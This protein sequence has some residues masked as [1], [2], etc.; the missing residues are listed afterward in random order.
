MSIEAQHGNQG[1]VNLSGLS[2]RSKRNSLRLRTLPVRVTKRTTQA[3]P[4]LHPVLRSLV[5][6]PPPVRP[7]GHPCTSLGPLP[8]SRTPTQTT[9]CRFCARQDRS[10]APQSSFFICHRCSLI[11]DITALI[12]KITGEIWQITGLCFQITAV[13]SQITGMISE[14]TTHRCQLTRMISVMTA[15]ICEITGRMSPIIRLI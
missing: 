15:E 10:L 4:S 11:S 5:R 14:I 1:A 12:A 2:P 9:I 3:V 7:E 6:R 8:A 13:I